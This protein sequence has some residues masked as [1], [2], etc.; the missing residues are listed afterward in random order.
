VNEVGDGDHVPVCAASV[1]PTVLVPVILGVPADVKLNVFAFA[2][3]A[4]KVPT[5][6]AR[7]VK[8]A[9]KETLAFFLPPI[10][11]ILIVYLD[12]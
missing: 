12:S 8:T 5:R 9:E 11:R 1:C 4:V 10:A 2:S 7:I 6:I 3:C